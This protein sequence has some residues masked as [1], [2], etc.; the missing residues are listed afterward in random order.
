MRVARML[1]AAAAAVLA[2]AAPAAASPPTEGSGAGAVV[3]R[4]PTETRTADGNTI[5]VRETDGVVTGAF[6]GTFQQVVRGVIHKDGFVTFHGFMTFTGVAGD[7]GAGTVTL[8]FE[9]KAIAGVPVAAGRLRTIDDGANTVDV[10]VIGTF[11][12]FATFFTYEGR[13]HCD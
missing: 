11:E 8:E 3:V 6:D 1:G 4:V 2:I 10:H 9:G 5:Q 13:F 12:E 7:C